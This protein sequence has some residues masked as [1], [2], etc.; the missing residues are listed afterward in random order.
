[1]DKATKKKTLTKRQKE[2]LTLLAQC[3]SVNEI[4]EELGLTSST[5]R[6]YL[7]S[8]RCKLGTQ[9][10]AVMFRYA[11]KEGLLKLNDN[12]NF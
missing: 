2:I 4:S 3:Y 7:H 11:V 6:N 10:N 1:M 8:I 9:S 5:I 12:E